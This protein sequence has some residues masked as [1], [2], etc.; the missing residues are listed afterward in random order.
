MRQSPRG[1]KP[2]PPLRSQ[3][4]TTPLSEM[5]TMNHYEIFISLSRVSITLLSIVSFLH[6]SFQVALPIFQDTTENRMDVGTRAV[7]P[8]ILDE[9][10]LEYSAVCR[11]NEGTAS[12]NQHNG[13]P[14]KKD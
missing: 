10:L 6:P 8:C 5:L 11:I 7:F 4:V 9:S 2:T 3:G 12:E 1:D 13:K 14:P